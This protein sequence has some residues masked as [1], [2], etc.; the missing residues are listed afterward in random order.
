MKLTLNAKVTLIITTIVVALGLA[1]SAFLLLTSQQ[2]MVKVIVARGTTMAESL[3]RGVAEGIASENLG[4]IRKVESIVKADDVILAQVYSTIWLP[5]D[6]YPKDNFGDLPDPVAMRTMK[7]GKAD[8]YVRNRNNIDFY[9]PVYY[10]HMEQPKE[11][12]YVIGYVRIKL[13]TSPVSAHILRNVIGYLSGSLLFT[14]L[15][16]LILNGFIR[17]AVLNPIRRLDRAISGAVTSDS[18]EMVTVSSQDE[19][20]ELS[21]HFN[22]MLLAIQERERNLRLS[23][24]LFST[25]FRVSPDAINIT[26]LRD[27]IYLEVN[28]GF[29]TMTGYAPEEVVGKP[30]SALDLWVDTGGRDRRLKELMERGLIINQEAQFRCKDGSVLT[31]SLSAKR[32]DVRGE[33]CILTVTRDISE[34]KRAEE[35]LR[36]SEA[37][38]RTLMDFM[39][40][41]VWWFG[42]DNRIQYINRCFTDQFGYTLDDIPTVAEWFTRAYPDQEYRDRYVHA[43][44]EA[45]AVARRSGSQVPPREAKVTCKDGTQRLIIINTQFA[46]GRTVE[47]FTDIT[48][49]EHVSAQLQKVEKLEAIGV[50]AGGIAHD[51]NNILTAI[52]GNISFARNYLDASHKS[53]EILGKAEKAATRA[54]ELAHQLLTFARGGQPIKK[55]ASMRHIIEESVSLVLRG[56]NVSCVLDIP[57]DLWAVEVDQG[58]ISQVINNLIIN[59][60]QAMPGGGAITVRGENTSVN[61]LGRLPLTPG[62]YVR[63]TIS[64]TGCGISEENQKR[65]FD[66]YFTTK[67]GGSGLG[68]ASAHSIVNKHGGYIGVRSAV[69]MGTTFEILLPASGKP[70]MSD[71]SDHVPVAFS[72]PVGHSVLVMD[73]EE[74]IRD[75]LADMLTQ[76]GYQA[77][78][79][80]DGEEA[81]SLYRAAKTIGSPF[82]AVIVDLTIPGGMG[83]REAAQHILAMDPDA[84]LIVSSG[85]SNDTVMAEF[86][87]FGF[88]A[89]LTKPYTLGAVA[90]T[91]SAILKT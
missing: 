9:A 78:T 69:G 40:S 73:D 64:D 34:R 62:H 67:A 33:D 58:Q 1:S 68:L 28:E 74:L 38:L 60:T 46:L 35:L 61:P 81:I 90:K 22:R 48:E 14:V 18:P 16:I 76:S 41:A 10:H 72:Q 87:T 82:S 45:I 31:G 65:I 44:N 71:D 85:Y 26:R 36:E 50:L 15:A 13:S 20:G 75:M 17:K 4:I 86:A 21:K 52:I 79:C 5:I 88:S 37:N 39:P 54:A 55:S 29:T 49:R 66:P 42:D 32:I 89:T 11:P 24:E 23:Q 77:Q 7:D 91:L 53:A 25:A 27:G 56:A 59:A 8:C 63:V 43:R 84:R 47:I 30:A 6:S 83:G 2:G 12:K 70:A 51:F 80:I 57:E 19:I 3:A